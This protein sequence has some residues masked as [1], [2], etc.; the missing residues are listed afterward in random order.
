M[1]K[2][3]LRRWGRKFRSDEIDKTKKRNS[4]VRERLLVGGSKGN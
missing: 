4:Y 2:V 3:K 1:S